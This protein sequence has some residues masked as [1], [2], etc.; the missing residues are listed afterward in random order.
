MSI[1][2]FEWPER[3]LFLRAI[4][5]VIGGFLVHLSLGT[6][7]TFGNIAPYIVSY[8]RNESHPMDLRQETT[9]WIF[10]C[11]L[12]GQGGAMFVGGWMVK[13]IGP[14]WTTLIGGWIMSLGVFLSYLTIQLSLWLLLLTYG[15]VFGIGVGIAYI[16]PLSSAM[17]WMPRWKGF[18]NGIVVSGFGLGALIFNTV[19][20]TYVNPQNLGTTADK[21][22]NE[23]FTDPELLSR[24]PILFLIL[25][26]SYATLQLVGS[27]LLTNPPKDYNISKNDSSPQERLLKSGQYREIDD[28]SNAHSKTLPL[29]MPKTSSINAI[30]MSAPTYICTDAPFHA[31]GS[32]EPFVGIQMDTE[33]SDSSRSS[34][35]NGMTDTEESMS[36][37]IPW[38]K[39]NVV[40]SL[41]PLQILKKP[42]FYLLWYMFLANG[43]SVTVISTM[44]KFFGQSFIIDDHF[45]ASVGA[46][47]AIFN[48]SGR[49]VWG[50]IADKISY[51]FALVVM[52]GVMTIF[53]LT[54][55]ASSITGRVMFF[56]WICVI[57]FCIGGSFSLFP[58]A[59]GR[60]FGLQ[61]VSVNY[62]LLFTSQVL[63]GS[64]GAVFSTFLKS[65]IGYDGLLF[66]VSGFS[67]S[68]FVIAILY[69]PKR[70]ISLQGK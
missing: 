59:V 42:S 37:V 39:K 52:S 36:S 46:V 3:F 21:E 4:L 48:C 18:A 66:I 69:K 41:K 16:G 55:F 28:N 49:I 56:I 53:T 24:V 30:T 19:Q 68:S 62:G 26:G 32:Q 51:K 9:T 8:I 33:L 63:A 70:Y 60:A 13:K 29:K 64:V 23:L 67:F 20:T 57:F 10:A 2:T 43:L 12:I 54:L 45:L 25:G 14:R 22:G 34:S 7:Y 5:V 11:S 58:T 44:Y 35:P 27:L 6:V 50:I 47:A 38:S 40:A 15:L 65:R 1:L 61:Y 17:S 31:E